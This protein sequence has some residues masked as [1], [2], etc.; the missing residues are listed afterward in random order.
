VART[1]LH[2]EPSLSP[3]P[4]APLHR[5]TIA[6]DADAVSLTLASGLTRRHP[7]DGCAVITVDAACHGRFVRM[8]ILERIVPEIGRFTVEE[9]LILITPPDRGAI[10]PGVARLPAAPGDAFVV[11]TEEWEALTRWLSGGGRLAACSVLELA[12]L[13][14]IASP[15]FAV[16]IGEVAAELA[17]EGVWEAAGP[18][19]G[20]GRSGLDDSLRP[21]Y[22]R[23]R[24]SPRAADALIAALARAAVP[25][26]ARRSTR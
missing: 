17:L 19:R 13:A 23:A 1:G 10:A 4:S 26:R 22:D 2:L 12:R 18:L 25:P 5:A 3:S 8:L 6:L 11:E 20:R 24:R 21:L 16:V 7:L 14:A 15:Q 9:R